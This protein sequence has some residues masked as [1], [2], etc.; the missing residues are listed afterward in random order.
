MLDYKED[1]SGELHIRGE[2]F[3]YLWGL[4]GYGLLMEDVMSVLYVPDTKGHWI[5][6]HDIKPDDFRQ[7][8]EADIRALIEEGVLAKV[9]NE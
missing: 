8:I 6:M 1:S 9:S 3:D 5:A 7:K 4:R 2:A